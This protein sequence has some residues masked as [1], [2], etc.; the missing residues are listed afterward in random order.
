MSE[1]PL[2]TDLPPVRT[3]GRRRKV[4]RAIMPLIF[5]LLFALVI[6]PWAQAQQAPASNVTGRTITAIGYP[7]NGG[8]TRVDLKSVGPIPAAGGEAKVDAKT[9][10]TKVEAQVQGLT[11]PTGLGAEFLTYVLWAVSPEGRPVNLGPLVLDKSG[12]G[13]L[14][15]TTTLQ[16]FSLFVTA[17]PYSTVRQPSEILVLENDLRKG[18][19]GKI[20]RVENYPL[21]KRSQYQKLG[22]PLALSMD[23]KN[24]PL[25][26]YEARNAV[27]IA[28]SRAADEYAK[29]IFTKADASLKMTENALARKAEKKEVVSLARQ[30]SQFAEDA[31]ALSVERQEQERIAKEKADAAAAAKAAAEEK[32]AAE[33]A[34]AKR[35]ADEEAKRQAELAAA[36]EAQLKAE[37][38]ARQAQLR[39][40]AAAREA[41]MKAEQEIADAKAKAEADRLKAQEEAAKAEA[42]RARQAAEALRAQ[43]LE[44]F[45][46][47]LTTRDTPRGLVITMA[48]VLFATGK[49]DL[50]PGTREQLAKVSGILIAHPGLHLDVEGHTDS[51]GS[52]EL[53]QRLSEKRAETVRDYMVGQGMDSQFLTAKG[54]GK[55]MPV[56]SNET[57]AGRQQNR[58]VEL[59]VSGEVI[60]VKIGK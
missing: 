5:T 11:P 13:E 57:A 33:A 42:E 35:K 46:R 4:K 1:R 9:G 40:E 14:K 25:E 19:K 56:A 36:R 24:V 21:M 49:Y 12:K 29:E 50:K 41:K 15:A 20:F 23:L 28:K 22:N 27:D 58:R 2:V 53:N 3:A 30:A 8:S 59:I 38:A 55:T 32:A 43:L 48:D 31:R 16:S 60:G 34:E 44:Q 51:T 10:V 45:N 18:T 6:T 7:V 47:I 52:D 26:V 37:A 17:E 39:A 54:F